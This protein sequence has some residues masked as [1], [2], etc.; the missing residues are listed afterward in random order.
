MASKVQRRIR[1]TGIILGV[2]PLSSLTGGLYQPLVWIFP[3][4]A[5]PL[6]Q[7]LLLSVWFLPVAVGLGLVDLGMTISNRIHAKESI[8]SSHEPKT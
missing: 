5:M 4:L 8:H 1:I 2:I 3:A 6:A 7:F